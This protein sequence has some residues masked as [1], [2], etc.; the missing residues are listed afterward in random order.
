[1]VFSKELEGFKI[2]FDNKKKNLQIYSIEFI[3]I[4]K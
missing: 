1:M 4:E 3:E 2:S